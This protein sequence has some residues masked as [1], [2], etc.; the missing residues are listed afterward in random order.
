[1]G[2]DLESTT[3][4]GVGSVL[5]GRRIL[6]VSVSYRP[7]HAG[8]GPYATAAANHLAALG[9]SVTAIAGMPHYPSWTLT[10]A[11]RRRLRRDDAVDGLPVVRLR[12]FVPRRQSV[13]SRGAYELSF[14]VHGL[15]MRRTWEPPDVVVTV[16]P[17]L[18]GARLAQLIAQRHGVPL[19]VIVQDLVTAATVQSGV[20]GGAFVAA[21][22]EQLERRLL[23]SATAVGLVH[24]SFV[25]RCYGLGVNPARVHIIPNWSLLTTG[26]VADGSG[27]ATGLAR[28]EG[29]DSRYVV[30]HAGNMGHKQGLEVL[31]HAARLA[32]ERGESELLFVL[33]GDGNRRDQLESMASGIPTLTIADPVPDEMF[34]STLAAADACLVTQR[35]EV[36]DMSVPSKLT[37]YF[38]AG[39]PVIASVALVGGTADEVRRAGGGVLVPPEDP[40]ALLE[41]VLEL[42]AAPARAAALGAAGQ[43]Y[44]RDRLGSAAGLNR[45][46]ALVAEGL[47]ASR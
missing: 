5:S 20:A 10:P 3:V 7:E 42:R 47:T 21:L 2:S 45:V 16:T 23:A 12:Q 25:Q 11:D 6:F 35:A 39:R 24:E 36:V 33:V 37:A 32:H 43:R 28:P 22:A 27:T 18:G 4:Q 17:S 15:L 38:S 41:A 19:V 29:W 13:L 26:T 31:V 40:A 30:L 9:A 46:A 1:M 8:I 34:A 14:L 44:A